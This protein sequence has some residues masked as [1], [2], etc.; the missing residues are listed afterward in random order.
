MTRRGARGARNLSNDTAVFAS[1]TR[2]FAGV[3]HGLPEDV[4][5]DM[6]FDFCDLESIKIKN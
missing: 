5:V 6:D 4:F 1:R 2:L 3:A